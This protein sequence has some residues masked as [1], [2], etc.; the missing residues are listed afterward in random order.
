MSLSRLL[1]DQ[2]GRLAAL[3]ALLEEELEALTAG[4]VDGGRLEGIA[5]EKQEL[6]AELERMEQL[7]RQVQQRLGYRDGHEGARDAARDAGCL[8]EWEAALDTTRRADRLNDLAGQLLSMR[9][10]HNQHMLDFLHEVSEKTL[11][12]PCGRTGRQPGRLNASA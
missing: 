5:A 11:Y 8:D 4:K 3:I 7:R 6:L 12:D 10:A 9:L 1:D 2:R